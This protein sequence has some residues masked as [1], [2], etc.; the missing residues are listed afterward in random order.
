MLQVFWS[1][2]KLFWQIC[3]NLRSRVDGGRCSDV[4]RLFQDWWRQIPSVSGVPAFFS[5]LGFL[6]LEGDSGDFGSICWGIALGESVWP[7]SSPRPL[8][9]LMGVLGERGFCP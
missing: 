2:V 9:L 7:R 5:E 8:P 1:V 4:I 6:G 3:S